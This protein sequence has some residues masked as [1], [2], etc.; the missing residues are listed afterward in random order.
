MKVKPRSIQSIYVK[1]KRVIQAGICDGVIVWLQQITDFMVENEKFNLLHVLWLFV[2][3][4]YN[5]FAVAGLPS[6]FL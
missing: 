2:I 1:D 4:C 3:F 6:I 5:P